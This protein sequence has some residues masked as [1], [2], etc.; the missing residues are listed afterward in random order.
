M[1]YSFRQ[2]NFSDL[3]QRRLVYILISRNLQEVVK[4]SEVL[5]TMPTDHAALFVLF[6]ISTNLKKVHAYGN[7]TIP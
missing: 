1:Q 3:I 5:C 4:N 7:L 2:Q 6:N